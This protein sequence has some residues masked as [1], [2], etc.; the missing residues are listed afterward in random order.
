[1]P[2]NVLL[3]VC[4]VAGEAMESGR[5]WF[6]HPPF[7]LP[8]R[9]V[10]ACDPK[11][12]VRPTALRY[13]T[14]LF[15]ELLRFG[16]P[17]PPVLAG[18]WWV[19]VASTAGPAAVCGAAVAAEAALCG[20]A[21]AVKWGLLGRIRPGQHPFWACWCGRWDLLYVAWESWARPTMLHLE[22][23]LLLSWYLRAM[24]ARLGKRVVLGPGFAQVVDPDMLIIEDDATVSA[25]FQAHTFED[26]VLKMD[27][28]HVR[29]GATVGTASVP[30]YGADIGAGAYVAPHSVVMKD[31]HL[32][33]GVRYAG[34]PTDVFKALQEQI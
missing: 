32:L 8:R 13:C 14:R 12:T 26:R 22:G 27:Y 24:G 3:G 23:T 7:E 21:L 16:L 25:Q 29:R 31:E 33:P 34:A 4:T 20:L 6:G 17:I 19:R 18:L 30:M 5:S 9:E 2:D 28:V 10:V 15:W 1:L 11:L